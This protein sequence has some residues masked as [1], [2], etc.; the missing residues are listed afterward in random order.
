MRTIK[1]ITQSIASNLVAIGLNLSTSAVAE[2]R[3]WASA[4]ATA[5]ASIEAIFDEFRR[6]IDLKVYRNAPGTARWCAEVAKRFQNGHEYKFDPATMQMYY[7]VIDPAAQIVS[8]VSVTEGL[9]VV[10]FKVAKQSEGAISPLSE[11]ELRNFKGYIYSVMPAGIKS[12]VISTTP[13]SIRYEMNV[14]Y[15]AAYPYNAMLELVQSALAEFRT[16]LDFNSMFYRQ[17]FIDAVMNIEGVVT[18]D[19]A[20]IESASAS[21]PEHTAM[22]VAAELESGYFDYDPQSVLNVKAISELR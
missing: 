6:E 3:S 2:W 16:S 13:D 11:D 17:R 9:K 7:D 12:A 21:R 20:K 14:Y 15:D 10:S 8:I 19:L 18:V 22:G 5:I 4:I 1:E